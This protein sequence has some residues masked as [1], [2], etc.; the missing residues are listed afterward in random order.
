LDSGADVLTLRNMK[1]YD[2]LM[3]A[4][5]F[6]IETAQIHEI[7]FA[8]KARGVNLN[9][10]DISGATP[11]HECS[12]RNLSLSIQTLVS[13]GADVNTKHGR[14][15]LTPLQ[16]AC[17][18][19]EPNAETVRSLLDKGACPNW[20]DTNKRTAFDL[21]L[22]S[23]ELKGQS[24]DT[25]NPVGLRQTVDEVQEFVLERLPALLEIVKKGGR[26][27]PEGIAMLRP[28]FQDMINETQKAWKDAGE[29][30]NFLDYVK[31]QRDEAFLPKSWTA[32]SASAACLLCLDK[33]SMSNRRHHCRSCGV[34]CCDACSSKRLRLR[35]SATSPKDSNAAKKFEPERACDSC[36]NRLVFEYYQ[37]CLTLARL[38]REQQR[39]EQRMAEER[40]MQR[41]GSTGAASGASSS[42]NG[43][44]RN[45]SS[46]QLFNN[47]GD[48]SPVSMTAQ[49]MQA[50]SEAMRNLEERGERLQQAAERSEEMRV[51]ASEFRSMTRQLLNQQQ[52]RAGMR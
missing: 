7:V 26:Y 46:Q 31:S 30:E 20:K 24:G 22:H 33:F 42:T 1:D 32:D 11:L 18:N 51:A 3:M 9:R 49:P 44:R 39:Y 29:P 15:G 28:S 45:T 8:L 12:A 50:M 47:N 52:T 27:T 4:V 2:C 40:T 5:I 37:W 35:P 43:M 19:A 6:G 34:L 16:L 13:A 36:F 48:L 10:F 41:T 21:V 25:S 17:S 23:R 14:S 38:R